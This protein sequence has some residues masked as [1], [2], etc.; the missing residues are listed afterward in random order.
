MNARPFPRPVD[1]GRAQRYVDRLAEEL[2]GLKP[3][4]GS[5]RHHLD[6]TL[7]WG[8]TYQYSFLQQTSAP[9]PGQEILYLPMTPL[10]IH[11]TGSPRVWGVLM[12]CTFDTFSEWQGSHGT[13]WTVEFRLQ[14]GVGQANVQMSQYW[15]GNPVDGFTL[16]GS[17]STTP[18]F[19]QLTSIWPT[20]PAAEI[21]AYVVISGTQFGSPNTFSGSVSG[22]SAPIFSGAAAPP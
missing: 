19:G 3:R 1:F 16:Q 20:V 8:G 5:A 7:R 14:V 6:K 10:L 18:P 21:N 22:I 2:E 17:A 12:A 11:S 9:P 4:E 15:T 13:T